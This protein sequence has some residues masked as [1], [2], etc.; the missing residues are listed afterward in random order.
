MVSVVGLQAS[1][2]VVALASVGGG[3]CLGWRAG[4]NNRIWKAAGI[5][6]AAFLVLWFVAHFRTDWSYRVVPWR[7]Y[8]FYER[9]PLAFGVLFLVGICLRRAPRRLLRWLLGITGAIFGIH[10]VLAIGSPLIFRAA[11]QRLDADSSGSGPVAQSTG[12]S[13]GAAAAATFLRLHGVSAS[14]REV[15]MLA[16]ASPPHRHG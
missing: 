5:L 11:V 12:W 9:G 7:E 4:G 8:V 1:T 15:A 3:S 13:C 16:G 14:E 2:L 6:T 10:S